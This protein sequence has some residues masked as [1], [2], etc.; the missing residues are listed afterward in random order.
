MARTFHLRGVVVAALGLMIVAAPAAAEQTTINKDDLA[1]CHAE[2][3]EAHRL[4]IAENGTKR[5]DDRS[6]FWSSGISCGSDGECWGGFLI[7]DLAF[8]SSGEKAIR[9]RASGEAGVPTEANRARSAK[10]AT[11]Y[12]NI[13][14]ARVWVAKADGVPFI[15]FGGRSAQP[16]DSAPTAGSTRGL[17]NDQSA[18]VSR[19]AGSAAA[20]HKVHNPA[21]DAK[22][23]VKVVQTSASTEARISGNFYVL[24]E[25][26]T[27]VEVF[28]CFPRPDGFCRN[29]GTW[30]V[31]TG[32]KWPIGDNEA[33]IRWG[34]CR[35]E[36]RF[37]TKDGR[38]DGDTDGA[39]YS[40]E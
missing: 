36:G 31:D 18:Q 30:R 3:A 21:N 11:W 13:C 23:C 38:A 1:L 10:D 27:P 40:C 32:M 16:N 14:M 9:A 2:I 25:C 33:S 15:S 26:A 6:W 17:A 5:S 24:N 12:A 7:N 8:S 20:A 29:G 28:W 4:T 19:A 22:S 34:A 39:S 37:K 35:G